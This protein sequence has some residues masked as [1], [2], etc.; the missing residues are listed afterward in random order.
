[1]SDTSRTTR[2]AQPP[3][4]AVILGTNEIAS[5]TA[6]FLL[7][8][9]YVVVLSNDPSCPVLRRKMAFHD[10]LYDDEVDV[11]GVRALRSLAALT[12]GVGPGFTAGATCHFAIETLPER[13][14]EIV[15]EG[16]TCPPDGIPRPLG[17][18]GAERFVAAPVASTWHTALEIGTRVYESLVLGVVD[19]ISLTAPLD[20]TRAAPCATAP[21]CKPEPS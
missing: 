10:A 8:Q 2:L 7:R 6:V 9:G 3:P 4:F 16:A 12:I 13:A 11:S 19:E 17:D 5:A 1:M 15:A 20:G 18:C 14:G 21:R